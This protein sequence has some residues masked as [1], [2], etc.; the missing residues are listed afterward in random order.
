MHT[1]S[2]AGL[3]PSGQPSARRYFTPASLFTPWAGAQL[4][5]QAHA[6]RDYRHWL[7]HGKRTAAPPS[8]APNAAYATLT[9]F[10]QACNLA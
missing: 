5:T 6:I 8:V 7:A 1:A 4:V 2:S 3:W 9:S 10:L